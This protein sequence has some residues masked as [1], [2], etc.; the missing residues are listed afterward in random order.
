MHFAWENKIENRI[1]C[2]Y[3]TK[4]IHCFVYVACNMAV[5]VTSQVYRVNPKLKKT[6]T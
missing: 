6:N 4:K 5:F 1:K 3:I 2:I